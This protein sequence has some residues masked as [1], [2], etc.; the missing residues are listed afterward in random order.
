MSKARPKT[1]PIKLV[2]AERQP[3]I[4]KD[5]VARRAYELFLARGRAEGRDVEDWLEAKRQ[6]EAESGSGR[7]VR[8]EVP[9]T[10]PRDL[11]VGYSV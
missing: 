9:Q 7:G 3:E 6:L 10:S 4:T 11:Q 8:S 1:K 5:D 2:V